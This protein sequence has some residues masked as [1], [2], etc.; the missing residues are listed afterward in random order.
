[1]CVDSYCTVQT[2]IVF[3]KAQRYKYVTS[4]DYRSSTVGS[5]LIN[6]PGK[7]SVGSA[8][9]CHAALLTRV[10]DVSEEALFLSF[11]Q[12]RNT[13]LTAA[14]HNM[15]TICLLIFMLSMLSFIFETSKSNILHR[16][17]TFNE[18]IQYF[19]NCINGS[20]TDNFS[21]LHT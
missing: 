4:D 10:K 2:H 17:W 8:S 14:H 21:Q 18:A 9:T 15:S 19:H 6:Q 1:M 5:A 20:Y 7:L 11:P 12:G 16:A 3:D 13:T